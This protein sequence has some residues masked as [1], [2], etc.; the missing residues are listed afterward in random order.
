MSARPTGRRVP[1]TVADAKARLHDAE[2]FLDAAETAADPDVVATN[3]IH[4]AIA[5]A[6]AICCVALRERP[7]G[8]SHAAAVQLLSRV[9]TTLAGA[10]RRSLDRKTQAAYE[11]R[12]IAAEDAAACVRHA[13]ALIDAAN[14]RVLGL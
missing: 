6:D 14:S 9:N 7:A 12:D 13:R 3:A 8:G 4:A 11:S 2:A 1:C 5:A 10:L